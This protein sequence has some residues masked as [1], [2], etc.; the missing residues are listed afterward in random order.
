MGNAPSDV[1]AG[2][3]ASRRVG[4]AAAWDSKGHEV[5]VELKRSPS[6]DLD[7][8]SRSKGLTNRLNPFANKRL[9]DTH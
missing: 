4:V 7:E 1:E 6:V 8:R 2:E 5:S 3:G 9:D